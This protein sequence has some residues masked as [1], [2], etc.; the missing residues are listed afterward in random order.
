[1]KKIALIYTGQGSQFAGMGRELYETDEKARKIFD[2]IFD[3][4]QNDL[5]QVMFYGPDEKL[6]QTYYSQ[7][8]ITALAIVLTKKLQEENKIENINVVTGH[9]LGEYISLFAAKKIDMKTLV[10]LIDFRGK[11]MQEESEKFS[12]GMVSVLGMEAEKIENLIKN[13]E[14]VWIVN[15]NEKNQTVIAGDKKNLEL[16]VEILKENKARRCIALNVAGAFHTNFM[17]NA[18]EKLKSEIEKINFEKSEIK[19]ISNVNGKIV[20]DDELKNELYLHTFNPVKWIDV[21]KTLEENV[22]EIYEIGAKITLIPLIKKI[23]EKNFNLVR[24]TI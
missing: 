1:M 8:A 19:I 16:A 13:L 6:N 3:I 18:A 11:V 9:S 15:Y 7:L 21:V 14:N 4:L 2:E 20:Q 12:G 24:I 23:S 17:K 10:K 22:D 5:K